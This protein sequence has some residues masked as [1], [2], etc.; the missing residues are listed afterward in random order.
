MGETSELCRANE[1]T[2][3]DGKR[4]IQQLT[5]ATPPLPPDPFS[6]SYFLCRSNVLL[7]SVSLLQIVDVCLSFP[8]ST[9]HSIS[10]TRQIIRI[11]APS[12][13]ML[14]C[15]SGGVWEPENELLADNSLLATL[16]Q[17]KEMG[18]VERRW[19]NRREVSAT[20]PFQ[21]YGQEHGMSLKSCCPLCPER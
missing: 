16:H 10:F 2:M 13:Q 18:R 7:F 4:P 3:S 12:H 6:Q 8:N 17:T 20:C 1:G 9:C 14:I 19:A 15:Y 21:L 11:K 5:A